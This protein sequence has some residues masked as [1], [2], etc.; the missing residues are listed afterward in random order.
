M[1]IERRLKI[2]AAETDAALKKAL[3]KCSASPR[4]GEAM[5]Y[6]S[7]TGGKRVRPFLVL[8]TAALFGL[9]PKRALAPA[10]AI[11]LVHTYSLV[12]DDLP[13]MDDDDL[14]RGKPTCHKKFD[15]ATAILAGDAL[16]TLAFELLA[17]GSKGSDPSG[18]VAG[19]VAL[20]ARA[21]G[22]AGMV[23][24]QALDLATQSST[25]S[26]A[27][28]RNVNGLKTGCLIQ[29]SVELGALWAGA[30][31]AA[32]RALAAYGETI[33]F[34]FQVVDDII[35]G[36]GYVRLMS[37]KAAYRKAAEL[38]DAAKRQLK[39]FGKKSAVL[40]EFAD[41]LYQRTK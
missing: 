5:R 18:T 10:C 17:T 1:D 13:A 36:D 16:L 27:V 30:A 23:G 32:R 14:R 28:M 29:V 12:H 26:L 2:R 41:F 15:E 21:A 11:E 8:E 31:P 37:V 33:G 6:A 24:G 40:A 20:L 22:A 7:M 25:P 39:P 38:R 34:L 19:G 4:L 35:D 3:R 9:S